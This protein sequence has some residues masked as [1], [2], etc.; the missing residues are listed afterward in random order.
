[1]IVMP[2][3]NRPDYLTRALDSWCLVEG[4]TEHPFLIRCEPGSPEVL[5][6]LRAFDSRLDLRVKVNREVLGVTANPF[7]SLCDGFEQAEFVVYSEDDVEIADDTLQLADFCRQRFTDVDAVLFTQRWWTPVTG[8]DEH[9]VLVKPVFA[10][11]GWG[12]WADRWDRIRDV[13][14]ENPKGWDWSVN[15]LILAGRWK[16]AVPSYARSQHYGLR[17]EHMTADLF[18]SHLC[19]TF[20]TSHSPGTW[21]VVKH[22]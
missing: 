10:A 22:V 18:A 12:T 15:D 17:G 9:T 4:V 20:S 11:T 6:V 21:R 13:W 5:E 8:E 3:F 16:A 7:Q 14:F 2:V 1:M 19:P